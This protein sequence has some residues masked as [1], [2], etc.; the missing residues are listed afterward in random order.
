[1]GFPIWGPSPIP[2]LARNLRGW[3]SQDAHAHRHKMHV[4]NSGPH[5][6]GVTRCTCSIRMITPFSSPNDALV[7]SHPRVSQDARG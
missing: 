6:V 1:M 3:A 4:D 7:G 5:R 2:V